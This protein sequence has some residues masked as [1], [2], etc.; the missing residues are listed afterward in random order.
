MDPMGPIGPITYT[1]PHHQLDPNFWH[2]EV[3]GFRRPVTPHR[4][5]YN[6]N[7]ENKPFENLGGGFKYFSFSPLFLG[8]DPILTNIFQMGWNHQLDRYLLLTVICVTFQCHVSCRRGKT[9]WS[10]QPFKW[11]R[12]R[13]PQP[14]LSHQQNYDLI[15]DLFR[16]LGLTFKDP[17]LPNIYFV[18]IGSAIWG[19]F[20][21]CSCCL[22]ST[23][24]DDCLSTSGSSASLWDDWRVRRVPWPCRTCG[25][26]GFG[27]GRIPLRWGV[28]YAY[29]SLLASWWWTV[30]PL[31]SMQWCYAWWNGR[32]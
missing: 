13:K 20:S 7:M 19:S 29:P 11:F 31:S 15:D 23:A 12:L 25:S 24:P 17:N 16:N 30:A 3:S 14:I 9:R 22:W 18:R 8:N 10:S 21:F 1:K 6:M 2:P 32:T 4:K 5:L 28:S 27:W 26:Q